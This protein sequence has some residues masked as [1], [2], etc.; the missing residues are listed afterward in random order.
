MIENSPNLKR[1][2]FKSDKMVKILFYSKK[3][4]YHMMFQ[5]Y[6]KNLNGKT[7]IVS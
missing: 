4:I 7:L 3:S 2:K 1:F 5:L 6:I